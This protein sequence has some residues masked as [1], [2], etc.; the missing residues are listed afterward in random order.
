MLLLSHSLSRYFIILFDTQG[1]RN[2]AKFSLKGPAK[3]LVKVKDDI[4]GIPDL[5]I[6]K[7]EC[8]TCHHDAQCM[9]L[10]CV[11]PLDNGIVGQCAGRDGSV[12][13]DGCLCAYDDD[14]SSGYCNWSL[15]CATKLDIGEEGCTEDDDCNNSYCRGT[16]PP[17]VCTALVAPGSLCFNDGDCSTQDCGWES[18]TCPM[19]CKGTV[20]PTSAPTRTPLPNGS[21][22]V[23]DQ[24][25]A[26][27]QCRCAPAFLGGACACSPVE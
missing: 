9:S 8:E 12:D 10:N 18:I 15:S 21:T 24:D 1:L 23:D 11:M 14:C 5:P 2:A 20:A 22:C 27:G 19:C 6:L 17:Y 13:G 16:I 25:C 4:P 26:S 3:N 7:G